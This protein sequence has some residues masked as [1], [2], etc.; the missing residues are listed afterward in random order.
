PASY[1]TKP[2]P[3][4]DE[5]RPVAGSLAERR[6]S[7]A[8]LVKDDSLERRDTREERRRRVLLPEELRVVQASDDDPFVAAADVPRRVAIGVRDREERGQELTSALDRERLLV[9]AQRRDEDLAREVE[10]RRIEPSDD[11]PGPLDKLDD[12]V[13]ERFVRDRHARDGRR[14][15]RERRS[16]NRAPLRG[17]D[18][19]ARPAQRVDVTVRVI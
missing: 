1:R 7:P 6:V 2:A 3:V 4:G 15:L 12:L 17:L 8:L 10:E 13:E 18:E 19:D 9:M 14:R 11:D 16:E 5:R